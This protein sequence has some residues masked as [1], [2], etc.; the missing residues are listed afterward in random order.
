MA[1]KYEFLRTHRKIRVC[2]QGDYHFAFAVNIFKGDDF[3]RRKVMWFSSGW[4]YEP[5]NI[6]EYLKHA[7]ESE[8]VQGLESGDYT[9]Y[10]YDRDGNE[11]T[12]NL[13][14]HDHGI[15]DAFKRTLH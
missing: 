8:I 15:L 4:G 2:S 7:V 10:E 5:R 11:R 1:R 9:F 12:E 14:Y 3:V 6:P 13:R